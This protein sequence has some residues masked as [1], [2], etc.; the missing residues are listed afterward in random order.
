MSSEEE[1][2]ETQLGSSISFSARPAFIASNSSEDESDDDSNDVTSTGRQQ[3]TSSDITGKNG[4]LWT[5]SQP[6]LTGRTAAHNVFTASPGVLS[7]VSCTITTPHD[8]WKMFI[9]DSILKSITKFTTD[10]AVRCGDVDFSLTLDELES[11]I[12]L[13]YARGVYE[14]NYPVP[15]LWNKNYGIPIFGETMPR[16]KFTKIMKYLRFDDNPNRI[17]RGPGADKFAPIRDVFTTFISLR[18]SKY[19]CDL[20]LTVDEQ[21]MPLKSRCSFIIFMPNKPDKYGIKFWILLDVKAK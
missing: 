9:H 3:A 15:F 19:T 7:S 17:R 21:L 18:K 12:A 20:S 8:A 4:S 13:Q 1:D 16:N 14:K 5:S 11:F 6:A 10:E 2:T